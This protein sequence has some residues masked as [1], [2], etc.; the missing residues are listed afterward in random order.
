[1]KIEDY[2]DQIQS[3]V[4]VIC[5]SKMADSIEETLKRA[6][7]VGDLEMAKERLGLLVDSCLE[8]YKEEDFKDKDERAAFVRFRDVIKNVEG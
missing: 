1:M 5:W 7:V 4:N 2:E 6:R 8:G 3:S